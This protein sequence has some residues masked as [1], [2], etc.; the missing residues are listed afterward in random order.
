MTLIEINWKPTD[1]QLRQFGCICLVALPLVAWL[2]GGGPRLIVGLAVAGGLLAAAGWA[3]PQVLRPVF[4]ALSLMAT[5]IGLLLGE[6]AMLLIYFGVFLPIGL[7]FRVIG[8]DALGRRFE[9][10]ASSYWQPK[11]QPRDVASYYRQS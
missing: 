9:P 2:W 8:R 6:L 3:W 11:K 10:E 4:L 1:R 5:P 7:V